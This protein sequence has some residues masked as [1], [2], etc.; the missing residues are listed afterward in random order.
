LSTCCI[1]ANHCLYLNHTMLK[2]RLFSYLNR[3]WNPFKIF[4]KFNCWEIWMALLTKIPMVCYHTRIFIV[5]LYSKMLTEA[6]TGTR[7]L[8][9]LFGNYNTKQTLYQ[10]CT[11]IE[12]GSAFIRHG[13]WLV[14]FLPHTLLIQT[15]RHKWSLTHIKYN[16]TCDQQRIFKILKADKYYR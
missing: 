2:F 12:S 11:K 8:D 9:W 13:Y 1:L 3:N 6:S 7:L 14:L 16:E 5:R 10:V 4:S 15:D